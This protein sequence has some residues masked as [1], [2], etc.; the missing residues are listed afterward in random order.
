MTDAWRAW[1]PI[2]RE[3]IVR[4]AVEHGIEPV[5]LAAVVW[6][7]SNGGLRLVPGEGMIFHPRFLYRY[8]PAYW[9]RYLEGKPAWAPPAGAES[10][11]ALEAW[12]RRVSASY[13]L[14]QLMY[15]TAVWLLKGERFEPEELLEPGL[16]C[17]LGARLLA[18]H[19]AAGATWRE[20]LAAYN[21]GRARPE[22]TDYDDF[23]LEKER[24][25]RAAGA[26]S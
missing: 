9:R 25:L 12:K 16:S 2:Y 10:G 1:L 21:T 23:V 8:E 26:F 13:G 7:E 3:H 20:A 14:C 15:P 17:E 24:A 19:L 6:Q 5:R 22:L 4:A 18:S 11:P